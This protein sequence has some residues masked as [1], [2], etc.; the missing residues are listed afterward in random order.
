MIA[1]QALGEPTRYRGRQPSRGKSP[2]RGEE[3][4]PKGK[5]EAAITATLKQ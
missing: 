4:D 5:K 3:G 1:Q 2:S